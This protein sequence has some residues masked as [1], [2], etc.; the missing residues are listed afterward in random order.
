MRAVRVAIEPWSPEYGG[1][2]ESQSLTPTDAA[3]DV[4]VELPAANWRPLDPPPDVAIPECIDFIDG[5]RRIDARVWLTM[6]DGSTRMG[7]C[8][9]FAAGRVRCAGTTSQIAHAEV[10][11][12]LFAPAG[13][14]D[15]ET[16]AG[17]WIAMPVASDDP[18]RLSQGV[19]ER[20]ADL[21]RSIAGGIDDTLL[22]LD[23]PLTGKLDVV[24]AVGYVKTHRVAYLPG[25]GT[26]DGGAPGD[27]IAR[28]ANGQR[29]PLFL[30]QGTWSRY[31]WYLRLPCSGGHA[32]AGIVRCEASADV[33]LAAARRLADTTAAALPR[34]A[35]K[36]HK[37]P[38]APQNLY[39]IAGLERELRRR[40]GDAAWVWRAL[41]SPL[42]LRAAESGGAP[43]GAAR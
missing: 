35:S 40:L 18:D 14:P 37:D 34:F 28:L 3:V 30:T 8:A 4:D 10:R 15:L 12:G 25:S 1:S 6:E 7:L 17:I 39:P 32:W 29:S 2:V 23:G 43:A 5:V 9:S 38:R 19:Q 24:G 36:P 21:E 20:M 26:D 13:A 41:S 27:V 31:S 16:R 33:P 22:V 42:R 11:R